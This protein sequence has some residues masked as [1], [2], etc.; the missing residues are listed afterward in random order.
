MKK[1]GAEFMKIIIRK[2]TVNDVAGL[3]Q[4]MQVISNGPGDRKKMGRLIDQMKMDEQK[5]LLV[6]VDEEKNEIVGS[7]LGVVFEDI[8]GDC[9]PILLVENVAVLEKCQG[10][11][12]G[13]MMFNE[14]ERWGR[15]MDCHYE[16]L[17]SGLNRAGAHKFYA[18]L[19]FDEVK[20]F[21]KY[22]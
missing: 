18:A 14:I 8:C 10:Q 6:A 13:R 7:L 19:G 16:M 22:L 1:E 17:V 4:V 11:G 20:G 9:R 3:D 12:V 15:E 21:K 2:A 5:Y